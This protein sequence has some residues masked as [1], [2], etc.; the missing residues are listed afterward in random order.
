M[1]RKRG[2]GSIFKQPGCSTW[3]IQYYA[4]NGKRVREATGSADYRAAQLKLRSRLVAIDRGEPIEPRQRQQVI[5]A[6]LYEGLRRHYRNNKLK[7][8]DA[9]ERRWLHLKSEFA[10]V[11]ARSV[12]RDKLDAYVDKRLGEGAANATVN[13]EL[14]ALKQALRLGADKHK[15]TVPQFPYLA[16]NNVRRGFI[17]QADFERLRGLATDLWLRLFL[18]IAFE[19]GW[20]KNE[21]LGLRVR[22]VNLLTSLIRL[23]VGTTKNLE[24]R[25]VTMSKNIRELVSQAVVGKNSDDQLLTRADRSPVKDFR[26]S[27]KNLCEKAGLSGLH[28][29]DFRRSAARELRKAGVPESTIMDIGGWKTREMFKRYAIT[30]TKDIAAAISKRE[31]ARIENSHDFGHDSPANCHA[32]LEPTTPRIN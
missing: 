12:T 10:E 4:Y 21:I 29:H 15:V 24:G 19:F 13:R 5:I 11:P 32:P 27:W 18:E 8:Q 26:K 6:V 22:Q 28:I 30:D 31:Q 1:T 23:D 9:V 25:E 2:N 14:A 7:S 3:T 17:E 16:E 20:R